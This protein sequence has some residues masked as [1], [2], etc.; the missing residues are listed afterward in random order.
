VI[1]TLPVRIDS[2]QSQQ[3]EARG[4]AR[5]AYLGVL[6]VG[7][8]IGAMGLGFPN[9]FPLALGMLVV[10]AGAILLRPIAGVYVIAFF[11][12]LADGSTMEPYPF[13]NNFSGRGSW[14]FISDKLTFSPL[15]LCIALTFASWFGHLAGARQWR[16]EGRP[17]LRPMLVFGGFVVFGLFFGLGVGGGDRVVAFW[18][19]RPLLYLVVMFVLVSNLL[20][21]KV[22][23]VALA[24]V[25][26][27][28]VTLQSIFAMKYLSTLTPD[29]LELKESLTDH[30]ASLFYAWLLLV[31]VALWV[32]KRTSLRARLL[33]TIAAVPVTIVFIVSQRR[34]A[35]IGLAAAFL[36]FLAV[37]FFRRRKVFL[38]IVPLVAIATVGYT[39]AFWNT[40]SGIGFGA[41]AIKSVLAPDQVT[42][43]DASSDFYREIENYDLAYTIRAEPVTGV[44]FGK[45]F[46]KP[47]QLPSISGFVFFEFIPHNSVLWIWLKVGFFGFVSLLFVLAVALRQGVRAAM[48]MPTGDALVITIGALCFV[49]MFATF[50]FVDIAWVAQPSIFLAICMATCVNI[51]RVAKAGG[52]TGEEP[53]Q[54]APTRARAR[55]AVGTRRDAL[56]S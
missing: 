46:Y 3:R 5:L 45:P 53:V 30:P 31:V 27:S 16:L 17:L 6:A 52:E 55:S 24:W 22:H 33:L 18:E 43:K 13:L 32:L 21:R 48:W 15:E 40:T 41:Q 51:V 54:Q 44:G 10:A 11:A 29:E 49:V 1:G 14:L 34:A 8:V 38:V 25:V 36:V 39:A 37:L 12:V 28:A 2:V 26:A 20:T 47:A 7:V 50:A 23:Y 9:P 35:I 56:I 4:T 19:V 42:E